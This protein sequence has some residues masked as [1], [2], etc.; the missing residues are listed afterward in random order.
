MF[1]RH[2]AAGRFVKRE[3]SEV[4][5]Q[6]EHRRPFYASPDQEWR[7]DAMIALLDELK[8][9]KTWSDLQERRFSEPLGYESWQIDHWLTCHRARRAA[10]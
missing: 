9:R 2:V 3:V 7:I 6:L 8:E 1:D 10:A 5:S 4:L